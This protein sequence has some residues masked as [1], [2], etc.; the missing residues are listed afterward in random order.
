MASAA[1]PASP[2][3][4]NDL[5]DWISSW[6]PFRNSG[7]S[8][9]ITIRLAS[10][11]SHFEFLFL[12][13]TA[14]IGFGGWISCNIVQEEN[15]GSLDPF[16]PFA[17][18][19]CARCHKIRS[20]STGGLKLISHGSCHLLAIFWFRRSRRVNWQIAGHTCAPCLWRI[21]FQAAA[22]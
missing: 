15:Q 7:G 21:D 13:R 6:S 11:G 8:S 22:H 10:R 14:L 12:E 18:P 9:T 16:F 3:T 1:V 5:S 20:P 4:A 2:Q 17:A 19:C